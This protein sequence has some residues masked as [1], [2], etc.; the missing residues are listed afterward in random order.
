MEKSR[1]YLSLD[2]LEEDQCSKL[3]I[4]DAKVPK[5]PGGT[6][7]GLWKRIKILE[8]TIM[9]ALDRDWRR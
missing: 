7:R 4:I 6:V 1:L 5:V 8:G 3:T 2:Y 9:H